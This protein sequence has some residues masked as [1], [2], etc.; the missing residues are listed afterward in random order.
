LRR[1]HIN[2]VSQVLLKRQTRTNLDKEPEIEIREAT[3][4]KE[5]IIDFEKNTY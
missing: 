5:I 1:T 3:E 2:S 4:E